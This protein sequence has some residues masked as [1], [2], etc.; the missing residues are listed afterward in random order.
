MILIGVLTVLA[1][2]AGAVVVGA[3]FGSSEVTTTSDQNVI[4]IMTDDQ[5]YDQLRFMPQVQSLLV[6]QGTSFVNFYTSTPN[7][8]PSRAAFY[9]GQMPHNNGVSDNVPPLGGAQKFASHLDQTIATWVQQ[10]GYYTASI[11]KFLNGWGNPE[12]PDLWT[13]GIEPPPGWTHWFGL[14]DPTTYGYYN[15][16]VSDDGTRRDYGNDPADYQTD[17]LGREVL[18]TITEGSQSGK[19]WF[20]S[21]T[22]LAPHVGAG[23]NVSTD[24]LYRGVLA[25]PSPAHAGKFADEPL[26]SSP[27]QVFDD[28]AL[29]SADLMNKPE[30]VR[31]RVSSFPTSEKYA[32]RTWRAALE[33]IQSVD[34]WVGEIY[35]H[36][37]ALGEL[38]RTTI[39][40]TSDNGFFHGEHGLWGKGLL[41]EEAVRV[42]LV[43]RG[44][45]FPPGATADQ[46][47]MMV[48]LAPTIL[49]ITA[50]DTSQ[51]L[52]GIDLRPL[53]V[54][55]S[56][57]ADRVVFLETSYT[58]SGGDSTV[59]VR[60]G[61]WAFMKWSSG[62]R[63][64]YD[65]SSD[66]YQMVN[67]IDDPPDMAALDL[68]DSLASQLAT[69]EGS[70]CYVLE[71]NLG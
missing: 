5:T 45:G 9:S 33:S 17:V 61:R 40:F 19:P 67:L 66:P 31:N 50:A 63:E 39:I 38:D 1:V 27:S 3:V 21:W 42:P 36:L 32:T 35:R 59:A 2:L 10:S 71:P 60:V 48:D 22:P 43:I 24:G 14:I 58:Y 23:E 57:S 37:D 53:A 47:T 65:L 4:V 29:R 25:I 41:Y 26:S 51:L 34:E 68:L 7:C 69:C 52:D 16:S 13:G 49:G 11:G 15:Y 6:E 12:K 8:C 44:P 64:L 46:M 55:P 18:D 56:L 28:A 70:T 20:I 62:E 54:D 30:R